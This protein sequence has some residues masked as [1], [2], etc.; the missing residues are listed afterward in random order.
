MHTDLDSEFS[1]SN[2]LV[3][4]ALIS[5]ATVLVLVAVSV[6]IWMGFAVSQATHILE[7]SGFTWQ[8]I[9]ESVKTGVQQAPQ[10]DVFG[11][12][13]VLILGLDT[14]ES[15]PGSKPLTDTILLAS[16]NVHTNSISL[17]SLPRDLWSD[18]S[19]VKINALYA[20]AIDLGTNPEFFVTNEIEQLTGLSIHHTVV[21]TLDTV[22]QLVDT[23]G[24]VPITIDQPFTDPLFPR[25][26]VDVT[27]V[28]DPAQL[29]ETITFEQG[30]QVLDGN[31]AVKFARSRHATG[32]EGSDL[33][34]AARQQKLVEAVVRKLLTPEIFTQPKV[35]EHLVQLYSAK[36]AQTLPLSELL[37]V[38]KVAVTSDKPVV[39]TRGNVSIFPDERDGV[40]EHPPEYLYSGQWVFVVKDASVFQHKVQELLG[41]QQL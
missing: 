20:E 39:I 28:R 40:I 27:V 21:L 16:Y 29:Y 8:G 41:Y 6:T 3:T 32:S 9:A 7:Q 4:T 31:T 14:L 37:S 26:D 30:A 33:A 38:A 24:G 22:A 2:S 15:R 12:K 19:Q 36:F 17:V 10:V 23:I 18:S 1:F 5:L 11:H 13:N 34:R 25:S 35:L